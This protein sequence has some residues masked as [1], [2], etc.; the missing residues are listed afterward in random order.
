[1]KK[2]RVYLDTSIPS[3][4]FADDSSEKQEITRQFWRLLTLGVYQPIISDIVFQEVLASKEPMQSQ[5]TE[6]LQMLDSELISV[7]EDTLALA[8]KYI[9]EQILPQRYRNDALH[10]ACAT[11]SQCDVLASWNFKHIVKL[12]TI[13]GVNGINQMLGY[14]EIKILTPQSLLEENQ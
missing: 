3:F 13:L 8:D 6:Q 9:Q 2:I 11:I 5:L 12:K 4:L 7:S 10:I 14:S 1:M